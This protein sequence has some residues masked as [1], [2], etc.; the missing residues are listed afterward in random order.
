M[1]VIT[2]GGKEK[3]PFLKPFFLLEN[4]KRIALIKQRTIDKGWYSS[5]WRIKPQ[6]AYI[7][8]FIP[9]PIAIE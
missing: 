9:M 8:K 1:Q 6:K 7:K 4:A 5:R 3:L 2:V